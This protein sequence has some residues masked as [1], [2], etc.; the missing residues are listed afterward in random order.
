MNK[1]YFQ[2]STVHILQ[3]IIMLI[4]L[5][6]LQRLVIVVS[7]RPSLTSAKKVIGM[8]SLCIRALYFAMQP[9]PGFHSIYLV[10]V[11]SL[12]ISDV[13]IKLF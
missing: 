12:H 9:V 7:M 11:N 3:L 8:T 10:K 6:G 4:I 5:H 2:L 13:K 1:S